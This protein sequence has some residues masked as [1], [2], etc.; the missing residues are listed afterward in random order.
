MPLKH[1]GKRTLRF[2]LHQAGGLQSVRYWNRN[3]F[4]I[5]MYHDFPSIPGIEDA[6]ARQCAHLT[7]HY[8]LVS[9]TDIARYLR[10]GAQLPKNALAITVDDG[11]RDFFIN[12]YPVFQ[13]HQIPVTV[14]LVS[15]FLDGDFWL[16]WDQIR[17][18]LERTKVPQFVFPILPGQP[19]VIFKLETSDQRECAI[20]TITRTLKYLTNNERR[21]ILSTLAETLNE[22]IPIDPP[23]HMAPMTWAEVRQLGKHRVDLGAHTVTHPVLSRVTDPQN[24]FIEIDR[25]KKRIE[26]EIGQPVTHFCYPYGL[27]EDFNLET[28][29][30]LDQCHFQ[31]AVTALHGMNSYDSNPLCL[32]RLSVDVLLPEFYFKERVAGLHSG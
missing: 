23:S 24:L 22:T 13:A 14:F 8:N 3:S 11:N 17:Y 28:T 1:L 21:P 9:M 5:L 16:W 12:A 27:K 25:S 20:E 19:P 2:L 15:G 26:Q 30:A 18:I 7:K 32:K 6:L 4:R 31:T 29:K 10:E